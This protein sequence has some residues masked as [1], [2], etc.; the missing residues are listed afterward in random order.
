MTLWGEQYSVQVAALTLQ[1]F[2]SNLYEFL[3]TSESHQATAPRLAS[4]MQL[5]CSAPKLCPSS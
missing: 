4:P 2:A 5:A 3:V 1:E